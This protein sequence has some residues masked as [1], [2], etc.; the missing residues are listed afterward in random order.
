MSRR[1]LSK[2]VVLGATALIVLL[3]ASVAEA[4]IPD[5]GGTIHGCYKNVGGDL[6]VIDPGTGVACSPSE[7]SLGWSQTGAKGLTGLQGA[8]GV[9]GAQGAPGPDGV[10]DYQIVTAQATTAVEGSG[11]AMAF[12]GADCPT[13]TTA[14]GGGFQIPASANVT[15]VNSSSDGQAWLV[16]A[17]GDAGVIVKVFAVCVDK[18]Q[19][20]VN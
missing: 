15:P 9:A 5:S 14:T 8:Q 11:A 17:T 1:R 19:L 3:G 10:A 2:K 4:T 13:G 20:G 18:Q 6:R 12:V 7:T 16:E